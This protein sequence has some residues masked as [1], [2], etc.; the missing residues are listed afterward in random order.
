MKGGNLL[1]SDIRCPELVLTERP[2][3]I[4]EKTVLGTVI[5]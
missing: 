4:P 2:L 1:I 3:F 5:T